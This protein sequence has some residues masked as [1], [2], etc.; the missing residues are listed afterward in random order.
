MSTI[1]TMIILYSIVYFI[2]IMDIILAYSQTLL[3]SIMNT[4]YI[5]IPYIIN[6]IIYYIIMYNYKVHYNLI[7][8]INIVP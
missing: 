5:I 8:N 7:Y 4:I 1:E 2:N 3:F 6:T